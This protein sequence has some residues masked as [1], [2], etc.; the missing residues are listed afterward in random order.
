MNDVGMCQDEHQLMCVG[1]T[2]VWN[3]QMQVY[4]HGHIQDIRRG[5]L[6]LSSDKWC[7]G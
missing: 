7:C 3:S 4:H 5:V 6:G 2:L 1:P